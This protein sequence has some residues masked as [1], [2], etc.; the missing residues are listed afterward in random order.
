MGSGCDVLY[1]PMNYAQ[2]TLIS[3]GLAGDVLGF[4]TY[5]ACVVYQ[6]KK[7]KCTKKKLLSRYMEDC[8]ALFD[9]VYMAGTEC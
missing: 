7:K 3:N 1:K 9:V 8:A 6:P 5:W 2:L 4:K